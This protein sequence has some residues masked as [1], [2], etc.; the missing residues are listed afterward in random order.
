V[1]E[2][3]ALGHDWVE[4][5]CLN[6]KTCRTCGGVEGKALGHSFP[7][8]EI[9][10]PAECEKEGE[11]VRVCHCGVR[12]TEKTEAL[13]HEYVKGSC[14]LCEELDPECLMGDVDFDGKLSYNDAL[15]VLRYSIGLESLENPAV[16]DITGDGNVNYEDALGILRAS[17]GL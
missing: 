8:W 9:A 13:S 14:V 17:I 4:A 11:R 1:A 10:V 7:E 5:D 12:E 3:P 16:A 6:A 2:L 15:K